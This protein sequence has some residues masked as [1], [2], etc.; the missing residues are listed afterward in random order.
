[1]AKVRFEGQETEVTDGSQ[2]VRA[3]E[4]LG[5]PLGCQD[6]LCG[7]CMSTVVQGMDNLEPLN[8]KERD[9]DLSDVQ[10]LAC[11]CK[12]IAGLVELSVD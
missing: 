1:M 4:E 3:V 5:L 10:R 9:M 12:I 6:G 8:D 2:I 11:Q 7:T